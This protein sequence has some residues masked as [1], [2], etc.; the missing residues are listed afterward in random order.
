MLLAHRFLAVMLIPSFSFRRRL[1]FAHVSLDQLQQRVLSL[2]SQVFY[3]LHLWSRVYCSS[4]LRVFTM[5]IETFLFFN[6]GFVATGVSLD[7]P[8]ERF[9][10]EATLPL[11]ANL[12][13]TFLL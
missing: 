8:I 9:C 7:F 1:Y 3:Q 13:K 5:L 6:L 12:S 11:S 10:L 2:G 4:F